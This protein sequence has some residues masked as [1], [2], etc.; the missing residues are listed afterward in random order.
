MYTFSFDLKFTKYGIYHSGITSI[1]SKMKILRG[2]WPMIFTKFWISF[3]KMLFQ[4]FTTVTITC[5]LF[6]GF[7]ASVLS[8]LTENQLYFILL[9]LK[10][11]ELFFQEWLGPLSICSVKRWFVA[12]CLSPFTS[13]VISEL[14]PV[15]H[16]VV[17]FGSWAVSFLLRTILFHHPDTSWP[18]FNFSKSVTRCFLAFLFY[19]LLVICSLLQTLCHYIHDNDEPTLSRLFLASIDVEKEVF[20][21]QGKYSSI[22]PFT[23]HPWSFRPFNDLDLFSAFLLSF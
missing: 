18:C 5:Y 15:T 16:H 19:K 8:S 1:E 23:C 13:S 4:T 3:L 9:L 6:V 7:S 14:I 10:H 21:H 22:I 11:P 12:F 20:L 17:C 2:E